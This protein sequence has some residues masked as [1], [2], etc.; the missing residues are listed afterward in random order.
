MDQL[1]AAINTRLSR[2]GRARSLS[3]GRLEVGVYGEVSNSELEWISA[4]LERRAASSFAS[5]PIE[6]ADE[7]LVTLAMALRDKGAKQ[8]TRDERVV[9][10]WVRLNAREFDP[11]RDTHLVTRQNE[12]G[13]W[14]VLVKMDPWNVTGDYLSTSTPGVD[15]R[16]GPAVNFTFNSR[17]ATLFGRL[18]RANQPNRTTGFWHYLGIVLDDELR[19]APRLND[20]ITQ[21]GQI[22]GN[23]TQEEVEFIISILNAGTLPCQIR[24]IAERPVGK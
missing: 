1:V 16:G 8:V 14:E 5:P 17:G 15:E 9:A 6:T 22:S 7:D 13:Q 20:V 21:H 18:T 10:R 11:Q 24:L 19:T 3:G 23:F 12:R 4:S 2:T